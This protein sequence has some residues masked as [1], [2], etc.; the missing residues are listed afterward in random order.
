V[1]GP[2]AGGKTIVLKTTGLC[3]LMAHAG[4]RVPAEEARI[5]VLQRV[6]VDIGDRQS[7]EGSL[8]TFS[9]H[10]QNLASITASLDPPCLVLIDEI[11][12]GTD[13]V[14]GGALAIALLEHLRARRADDATTHHGQ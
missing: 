4:L 10:I 7:I 14:E 3:A 5:P 12:T 1:S 8:S 2:N 11:G 9:A 6:L 13:P